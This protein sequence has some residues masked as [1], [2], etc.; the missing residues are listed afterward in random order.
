MR[1]EAPADVEFKAHVILGGYSLLR[2]LNR[3]DALTP[4]QANQ[5]RL[6]V[7][8][9]SSDIDK[10]ISRGGTECGANCR[11]PAEGVE[12]DPAN[13]SVVEIISPMRR[14]GPLNPDFGG[15]EVQRKA[16]PKPG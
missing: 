9:V 1:D 2:L 12:G 7:V 13:Y 15:D 11:Q 8:W 16:D 10:S 14:P 3:C 6:R 5:I 4:F